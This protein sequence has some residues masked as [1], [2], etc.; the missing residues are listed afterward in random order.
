MQVFFVES[1]CDDP[2]IIAENI[3]VRSITPGYVYLYVFVFLEAGMLCSQSN[4]KSAFTFQ[5][6][7]SGSPDYVDRDIDEAMED[8]IQRIECYRA[9]YMPIDDEKDRY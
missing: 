9:S 6:V 5:Q 3:K 2:E 4:S 8:F 7:K 1:I